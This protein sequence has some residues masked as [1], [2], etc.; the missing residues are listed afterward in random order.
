M[1]A[2]AFFLVGIIFLKCLTPAMDTAELAR[3]P[4]LIEHFRQHRAA[5]VTMDFFKFIA[6]HYANARHHEEDHSTHSQL[7]FGQHH[8]LNVVMQVWNAPSP[9]P[10]PFPLQ[11]CS[12]RYFTPS[13]QLVPVV[14]ITAVWQ[15][16]KAA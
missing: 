6:L 13:V 14:F 12:I 10:F 2:S 1:R 9:L 7:P 15:P 16:P 8:H 4:L 11:L 5:D 3:L